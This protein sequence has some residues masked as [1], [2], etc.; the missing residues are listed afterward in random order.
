ME[1]IYTFVGGT[2][3]F[4]EEQLLFQEDLKEPGSGFV[5]KGHAIR[6]A[7]ESPIDLSYGV[8]IDP[9]VHKIAARALPT[10]VEGI[11]GR[12][13]QTALRLVISQAESLTAKEETGVVRSDKN[14][15]PVDSTNRQV[16]ATNVLVITLLGNGLLTC[17]SASAGISRLNFSSAWSISRS[18]RATSSGLIL[19]RTLSPGSVI[20][21]CSRPR[22]G[23]AGPT[24]EPNA[25]GTERA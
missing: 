13:R 24:S 2:P 12:E 9:C 23:H 14:S 20:A 3:D 5:V 16:I 1:H 10:A 4:T 18:R 15:G 6:L 11:I 22:T 19:P 7:Y 21:S 17:A 8:L 25:G